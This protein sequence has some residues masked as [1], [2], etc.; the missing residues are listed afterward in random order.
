MTFDEVKKKVEEYYLDSMPDN[1][2]HDIELIREEMANV[3]NYQDL[4]NLL[5]GYGFNPYEAGEFIFD[6]ITS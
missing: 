5:D 3:K 2:P 6:A 4:T 1:D